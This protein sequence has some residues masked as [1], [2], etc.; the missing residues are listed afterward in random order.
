MIVRN[1][2][3]IIERCLNGV[4]DIVDCI[5]I[6]DTGST[7]NTIA[8]INNW[9]ETNKIKGKVHEEPFKNFSHNRTHSVQKAKETYPFVDYLLLSDADFVWE[10][11]INGVFNKRLLFSHKYV[12]TQYHNTLIYTNIRLLS[13]KLDWECVGVTHEYWHEIKNQNCPNEVLTSN[14]N[15]IRIKDMEDGG[16]KSDKFTRDKRLLLEGL[17]DPLT[18]EDLKCRYTFYLAQTCKCLKEYQSSI[19]YYKQRIEFKGWDEEVYYSYYQIGLN[20]KYLFD[21]YRHILS[22]LDKPE[23]N[24]EDENYIKEWNKDNLSNEELIDTKNKYFDLSLEY[25]IKAWEFRPTRAEALYNAVTLLRE[26]SHHQK[27]YDYALEGKKIKLSDDALFLEKEAYT[28]G[29]DFELAIVSFY[30]KKFTEGQEACD[31]LLDN[32]D[33]P[34]HILTQLEKISGFYN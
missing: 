10:L 24:E 15:T 22:L 9:C 34:D 26:Y 8:I 18:S 28:W 29:F 11:N 3:R 13:N 31:R 30:L 2:S 1:E 16:C 14:L 5:S 21:V 6:C 32:D 20:Y 25:Y 7:D 4:K 19:N 23:K 27:A 33:T 12:V 17:A